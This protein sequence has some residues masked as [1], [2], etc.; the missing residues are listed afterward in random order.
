MK[1]IRAMSK[2]AHRI[3]TLSIIV[4]FVLLNV[5]VKSTMLGVIMPNVTVPY[6]NSLA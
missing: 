1:V 6:L 4:K 3:T 2:T 5:T